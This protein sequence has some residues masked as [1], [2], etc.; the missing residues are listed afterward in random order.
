MDAALDA[1]VDTMEREADRRAIQGVD[2]PVFQNGREVGVV[3][4]YSDVLLMFRLNGQRP[5]KY[6]R[7]ERHEH[8][9]KDGGPIKTQEIDVSKLSTDKLRQLDEILAGAEVDPKP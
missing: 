4:K 1:Y 2:Q 5:E 9:G 3:R 8:T 7:W 6:K